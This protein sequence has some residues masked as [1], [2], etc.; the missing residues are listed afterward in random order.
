MQLVDEYQRAV[1]TNWVNASIIEIK[2]LQFKKINYGVV[3]SN[4]HY[5]QNY[6]VDLICTILVDHTFKIRGNVSKPLISILYT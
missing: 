4:A 3:G 6:Q 2:I 1:I 5:L